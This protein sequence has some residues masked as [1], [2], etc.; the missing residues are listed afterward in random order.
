M[1]DINEHSLIG[2]LA[3]DAS[4]F[5]ARDGK[6]AFVT[7]TVAVTRR[8]VA[9]G[10]HKARTER[11]R[12]K[13]WPASDAEFAE[14]SRDL[15]KDAWVRV[16][17]E[18]RHDVLRQE[19][20]TTREVYSIYAT[21]VEVGASDAAHATTGNAP[22]AEEHPPRAMRSEAAPVSQEAPPKAESTPV[23]AAVAKAAIDIEN[24]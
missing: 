15:R 4:L 10:V 21:K 22:A 17:G 8:W 16:V 2:R 9:G 23:S 1:W 5:P 11:F 14:L 6:R 18:G 20:G 19:D 7:F 13:Q 24:W 12:V 3:S